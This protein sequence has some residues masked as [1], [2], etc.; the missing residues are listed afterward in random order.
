MTKLVPIDYA[1]QSHLPQ[2]A[3]WGAATGCAY[4][5]ESVHG[6]WFTLP[7]GLDSPCSFAYCRRFQFSRACTG[8]IKRESGEPL[9]AIPE[10]Y[11]QL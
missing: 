4:S 2:R 9:R 7:T 3:E 1:T 11:P 10:L 5:A 6:A 8:W